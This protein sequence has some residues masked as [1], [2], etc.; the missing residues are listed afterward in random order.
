M[1]ANIL[2]SIIAGTIVGVLARL[3]LKGRQDVSF[4]VTVGIGIVGALV[5]NFLAQALGVESTKGVDWIRHALQVGVAMA[6]LAAFGA[7]RG[8]QA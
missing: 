1:L 3:L 2:W 5:G 8:R 6:G 4:P 7:I